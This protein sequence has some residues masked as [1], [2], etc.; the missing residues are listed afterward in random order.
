[1]NGS[2]GFGL[3]CGYVNDDR[4]FTLWKANP[5]YTFLNVF[6]MF[7]ILQWQSLMHI[8]GALDAAFKRKDTGY[9]ASLRPGQGHTHKEGGK[10][11]QIITQ[12]T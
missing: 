4:I 11:P 6:I 12:P 1:M 7:L 10:K 2:Y 9:A 8:T 5:I 3:I